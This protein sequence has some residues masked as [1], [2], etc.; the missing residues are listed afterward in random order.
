MAFEI[1]N[2]KEQTKDGKVKTGT[3]LE[4]SRKVK[5]NTRKTGT[6]YEQAACEYLEARGIQIVERNYRCRTGEIDIVAK[7][8]NCIV[9][10]EVKYR[11]TV[12]CGEA[13]GMVGYTKQK[14]ICQCARI[15]C[16]YHPWIREIRY[17]VIGITDTKI[18]W[19]QNAFEHMG[20]AWQ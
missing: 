7:D 6:F 20:Y 14:K 9:F 17:D 13:L 2:S 15:Y 3:V 12:I 19:I 1:N 10:V 8:K 11:K 16:M 4:R 5:L 18:E